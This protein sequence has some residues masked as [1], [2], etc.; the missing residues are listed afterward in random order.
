MKI[1][2][3]TVTF[4]C[5]NTISKTIESVI[6]QTYKNFEY[7]VI[8]GNSNDNTKNIINEYKD[9][10]STY[11][12]ENDNGIYDAI[13]KGI[14]LAK[15]EFIVILHSGDIFY[16]KLTIEHSI[17]EIQNYFNTDIF[18]SNILFIDNIENKKTLRKYSSKY[19]KPF[20]FRFGFMPAH[21]STI[22]RKKCFEDIGFYNIDYKIASDFD[23][24][25][26][27]IYL[28]NLNFKYIDM[29]F[30]YM[31]I[32]GISTSGFKSMIR[33]NNEI[34]QSLKSHNVYSNKIFIYFKYF[35]KIKSYIFR[36]IYTLE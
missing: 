14:R 6:S 1:S 36:N 15:G 31:T 19:F 11:I 13:N 9:N 34:L 18:F 21:T 16:N 27:F 12:S 8:D 30:T 20:M 7:I 23:L 32:G 2:I 3:I 33:I 35:F 26:N 5:Q 25:F 17:N 22:I 28:N 4:N 24:L 29:Y 10:I